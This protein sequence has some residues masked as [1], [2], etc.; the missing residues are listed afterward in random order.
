MKQRFSTLLPAAVTAIRKEFGQKEDNGEYT[1][2]KEIPREYQGYISSFGA[3]V[4]Q[5][6]LLPTLAVFGSQNEGGGSAQDRAKLLTVLQAILTSKASGIDS[7]LKQEIS[8]YSTKGK[9]S[10]PLFGF[11]VRVAGDQAK[12]RELRTH[13]MDAA[14]AAKLAIRTFQLSK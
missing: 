1:V 9:E 8:D 13:L 5:M 3:S 10:H 2:Q 12:Q 4:M 14:V 7:E 11:A 6:G